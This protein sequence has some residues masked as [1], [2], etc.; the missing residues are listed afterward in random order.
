MNEEAIIFLFGGGIVFTL[1]G[2]IWLFLYKKKFLYKNVNF[3]GDIGFRRSWYQLGGEKVAIFWSFIFG[4]IF[5]IA[6]I[7]LLIIVFILL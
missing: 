7:V 1:F 2:L 6:G 3:A 4:L 5:L